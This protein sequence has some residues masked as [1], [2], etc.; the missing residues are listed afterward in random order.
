[1][2]LTTGF[3][4]GRIIREWSMA[5][6]DGG[7]LRWQ[8][9]HADDTTAVHGA[10]AVRD[11]IVRIDCAVIDIGL[12]NFLV[13]GGCDDHPSRCLSFF[14]SAFVYDSLTHSV[15]PLPDMPCVRHGC[16]GAFIDGKAYVVG[17]EYADPGGA[18]KTLVSVFDFTS[19]AW[20]PLDTP[21]GTHSCAQTNPRAQ[22]RTYACVQMLA[23][24]R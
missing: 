24:C 1:M 14:R 12:G 3:A 21:I 20:T 13:A 6:L 18:G 17:G 22:A 15:S 10:D 4:M 2:A 5:T 16:G 9:I 11:G 7:Q 8:P 23:C 19:R